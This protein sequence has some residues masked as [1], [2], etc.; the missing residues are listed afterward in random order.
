M[1]KH[2]LLFFVIFSSAVIA[3]D[4]ILNVTG[5]GESKADAI[6][7][8]QRNALRVSYGEFVSSNLTT[9][10]NQLTK[11]ETVNLVSGTVKDF[12]VLSESVND[13]SIPPIVEVLLRVKVGKGQLISFAKAIGDKVEVQGS[14]FGAEIRQQELNKKNESVALEHLEKKAKLMSAFFDSEIKVGTPKQ[15]TINSNNYVIGSLVT[16]K[17]NKNYQNLISALETTLKDISMKKDERDKYRDLNTPIYGLKFITVKNPRCLELGAVGFRSYE[18]VNIGDISSS[19]SKPFHIV[20]DVMSPTKSDNIENEKQYIKK[21]YGITLYKNDLS[22]QDDRF[23]RHFTCS[24]GKFETIYF[25]T[26]KVVEVLR[27]INNHV[28]QSVFNYELYRVTN[29][30]KTILFPENLR[31]PSWIEASKFQLQS[32]S[33]KDGLKDHSIMGYVGFKNLILRHMPQ[34]DKERLLESNDWTIRLSDNNF[35]NYLKFVGRSFKDQSSRFFIGYYQPEGWISKAQF[36]P[37]AEMSDSNTIE[38]APISVVRKLCIEKI[39]YTSSCHFKSITHTIYSSGSG[40]HMSNIDV[41]NFLGA[42]HSYDKDMPF[43]ELF[44]MD[45][46]DK[47]LLSKITEYSIDPDKP[48][49]Y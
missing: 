24:I 18:G 46:V 45:I 47:D 48:T 5:I 40:N 17:P 4:L 13:F 9:L 16:L 29:S 30:S 10:N 39:E 14:L 32:P 6:L 25:R 28:S 36:F 41:S 20:W 23:G 22:Q 27:N 7:D 34:S 44:F 31:L 49:K 8:A 1:K 38:K 43:A 26:N 11:N 21:K 33:L 37:A 35:S 42:L 15:S 3:E 19:S 12:K 2:I